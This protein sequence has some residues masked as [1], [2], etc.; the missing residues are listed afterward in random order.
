[1]L[2][3]LVILALFAVG[4]GFIDVPGYLHA[5]AAEAAEH[6]SAAM[7]HFLAA[8]SV[9]V[10]LGGLALAWLF[11]VAK[12]ELPKRLAASFSAV[13]AILLNKYYVDEIYD[14]TIVSP[15]VET[16]REG[17]WKVVDVQIIDGAVNGLGAMARGAADALRRMQTG[18]VRA[19]A[20]WILL[21]GILIV[22][23]FLR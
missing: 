11:Y 19:Y 13:Y 10:A 21:G 1:M 4:A 3:P 20:A 15:I 2:I 12:P 14:K 17:F 18:Y 8:V 7:E 23:W 16:S 22:T 9:A 5:G 6:G